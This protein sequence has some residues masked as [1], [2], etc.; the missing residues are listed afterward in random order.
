MMNSSE[1]QPQAKAWTM[2]ASRIEDS[3]IGSG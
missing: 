3:F 1:Q 2:L